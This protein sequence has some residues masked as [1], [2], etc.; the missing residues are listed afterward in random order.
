[1]R[2]TNNAAKEASQSVDCSPQDWGIEFLDKALHLWDVW[3]SPA[4]GSLAL[5]TQKQCSRD[6][7]V[8][9]F[10]AEGSALILCLVF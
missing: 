5:R 2:S 6:G 9:D 1:M 3:P 4:C 10:A 7:S 8:V